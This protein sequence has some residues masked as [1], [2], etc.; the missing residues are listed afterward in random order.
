MRRMKSWLWLAL[1]PALLFADSRPF[2]VR[3]D[4][5]FVDVHPDKIV[6]LPQGDEMAAA[7]LSA[8][9]NLFAQFLDQIA[10][11]RA[12]RY[13]VFL[14][15]PGS[16]KLF[17]RLLPQMASRHIDLG[18]E[19]WEAHRPFAW[20]EFN[21]M[22]STNSP[23]AT[24][25]NNPATPQ[26]FVV[27]ELKENTLIFPDQRVMSRDELAVP[28]NPFELLVDQ[29][30]ANGGTNPCINFSFVIDNNLFWELMQIMRERAPNMTTHWQQWTLEQNTIDLSPT[31]IEAQTAGKT[32]VVFECRNN[33]LFAVS[34]DRLRQ[35]VEE[36]N[37][38]LAGIA[39]G[40]ETAFLR[41]AAIATIELDGQRLDFA[42]AL[43]DRYV[44][45]PVA[46]AAG[47]SIDD[48]MAETTDSWF[49]PICP[50]STGIRIT[51]PSLSV[52]TGSTSSAKPA[53]SAGVWGWNPPAV[54]WGQGN[55]SCWMRRSRRRPGSPRRRGQR[56]PTGKTARPLAGTGRSRTPAA[57]MPCGL[58][59]R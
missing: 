18:I 50:N 13:V 31:P 44:L 14:L 52:P 58:P 30:E 23:A 7:D 40:S 33:Q 38:E 54:C 27:L 20:N 24:N 48:P 45:S 41:N 12:R 53:R 1:I 35:A 36:K 51:S 11:V 3:R 2:N 29:L 37:A 26:K 55:P 43:M 32:P 28:G 49:A 21:R 4:P 56:K 8:P 15:R 39:E 19:P 17:L 42:Y 25:P 57:A 5:V 59:F 16:E 34:P 6:I 22:N 46:G 47:Y 9:D 10:E